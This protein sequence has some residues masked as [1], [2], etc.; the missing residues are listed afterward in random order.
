[1]ATVE[2]VDKPAVIG[3]NTEFT[4]VNGVFEK[5]PYPVIILRKA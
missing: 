1:M 4:S 3:Q 5:L 2:P